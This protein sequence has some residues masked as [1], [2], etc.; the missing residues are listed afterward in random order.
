MA[1][2][3]LVPVRIVESLRLR[4]G[5]RRRQ[6][7]VSL[8]LREPP[9]DAVGAAAARLELDQLTALAEELPFWVQ[10]TWIR[11]SV[12]LELEREIKARRHFLEDHLLDAPPPG[13]L[14]PIERNLAI[15]RFLAQKVE[16]LYAAGR[17]V[18]HGAYLAA[19]S[20]FKQEIEEFEIRMGLR[21][22]PS[23]APAKPVPA[24]ATAAEA[25][26]QAVAPKV[27]KPRE[28]L[29]W[30]KVWETLLSERTLRVLLFLGVALLFAAAV[31]LVVL[32]WELFPPWLQVFFMILNTGI[33]YGLG[34]Y[35]REKMGLRGSGIALSAVASLLIPLD[36]YALYLFGGF[37]REFWPEIWLVASVVS[38]G[39]YLLASYFIQADFFGYLVGI[40]AGSVLGAALQVGRVPLVWWQAALLGLALG[41]ALLS[42]WLLRR[43]SRWRVM[44]LPL[45]HAALSAAGVIL[46][47]GGGWALLG[48]S[49][50]EEFRIALMLDWWMVGL[51]FVM[52]AWRFRLQVLSLAA[53]ISF[54]LATWL[55]E[56]VLLNSWKVDTAWYA[57]G[58]VLLVPAYLLIGRRLLEFK[59]DKIFPAYGRTALVVAVL[60]SVGS[61]AWSFTEVAAAAVVHPWLAASI[62]L[63]AWMWRRPSLSYLASL[64]L[65]T[66]ANAWVG[67]RG[68]TVGQLGLAWALLAIGHVALAAF[69]LRRRGVEGYDGPVYL[70]GWL[71]AL[72]AVLPPLVTLDRPILNYA[73][74][75]LAG[76]SGWLAVLLHHRE[77]P[78]LRRMLEHRRW[79]PTLFH[80]AAA[81]PLLPWLWLVWTGYRPAGGPLGL[82]YLGLAWLL[83]GLGLW[84][85]RIQW[86]YGRPWLTVAHAANLIAVGTR[87]WLY[88]QGWTA[89]ILLLT[90]VFFFASARLLHN[91]FWL[92]AGAL[93]FPFGWTLGLNWLGL[94]DMPLLVCLA[95]VVV[96][97]VAVGGLLE[98]YRGVRRFFLRPLYTMAQFCGVF[99][100]GAILIVFSGDRADAALLWGAAG[101]MLL[102][103]GFGLYAWILEQER[104]GH[105][106]AWLGVFAGGFVAVAYSQGRGSSAAKAAMLAVL[107]IL[108]ERGLYQVSVS[109]R[110]RLGWR[111][112]FRKAWRLYRRP[113]LVAGW[114][115]SV[116][117]IVL[118]LVRNLL[119]LGGGWAR[120]NWAIAGLWI[121]T[122]LYALSAWLYRKHGFAGFFVWL[123]GGVAW[124]PWTLLSHLGWYVRGTPARSAYAVSWAVLGLIELL[125]AIGL[126]TWLP[127]G[128]RSGRWTHPLQVIAHLL[129][130]FSLFWGITNVETSVWTFGFG[131]AF[132]L[133][134]MWQDR[135]AK[136]HLSRRPLPDPRWRGCFLYP[137]AALVPVWALFLLAHFAPKAPQTTYGWMLLGFVLPVLFLGRWLER[138]EPSYGLP[139]YLVAYGT[140]VA[141]TVLLVHQRPALILALVF[142]AVVAG[143]SAWTFQEPRWLYPAVALL[144]AALVLTLI[145]WGVPADRRGWGLIGL[146][147]VYLFVTWLLR[148][149]W[150]ALHRYATPILAAALVLIALGLPPSSQDR[151]GAGVGYG[152]AAGLYALA[153]VWLRQPLLFTVAVGLAMVPYGAVV[154]KLG[155]A[156]IDY[157]LAMW[158]G[159]VAALLAAHGLDWKWGALAEGDEGRHSPLW[160]PEDLFPPFAGTGGSIVQ[161]LA[162]WFRALRARLTRWWALPLYIVAYAGAAVSILLS[163]PDRGRSALVLLLATVVYGLAVLRFRKRLW[164]LLALVSG[165]LA[166][167]LGIYWL[168]WADRSAKVAL[169]FA[170]VAWLTALAGLLVQWR[171]SEGA[172]MGRRRGSIWRGWSRPLYA[173]LL[174]DLVVC[175]LATLTFSAESGWV[176]LSS[177]LLTALLAAV[178]AFPVMA[179]LALLLGLAAMIQRLAWMGIDRL[180]WPTALAL[181]ALAYGLVGYL[182]SWRRKKSALPLQERSLWER[183]LCVG[184]WVLSTYSLLMAIGLGV[185]VVTFTMRAILGRPVIA[186]SDLPKVQMVVSVLSVVG[187]FYLAAAVVDRRRWPGY[188]AVGMLLGAWSL[189]WRL[190]WGMREVQWYAIPAGLYLLAVGY[191]EW[192]HGSRSLARWIDRAALVLLLGSSFWESLTR[193]PGWVY[194]FLMG[195][196]GGLILW[197]GSARR[198]RR[199]LYAGVL[200]ILIDI[201][202]QLVEPF[203]RADPIVFFVAGILVILIGILIERNLERVRAFS[204][205]RLEQLEDWE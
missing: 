163:L 145:E 16:E 193:E 73:L 94:R 92:V 190:V 5:R 147:G 181:L 38:L 134:A 174:V 173:V 10:W 42:E 98:R 177:A 159:I 120:E 101:Q 176:S 36:F 115:V 116:G 48:S 29:T 161:A 33:F 187:L 57:L 78:G 2:W 178:W 45:W 146:G 144:P 126:A 151:L 157:G 133:L 41:M 66:A 87:L 143:I 28:P 63:A 102:G 51:L 1:G 171:L 24:P 180:V 110:V 118:A 201:V 6:I 150:V 79:Q 167:V 183:P 137:A 43:E 196:E 76:I 55:T 185:D 194:A 184:G 204:R 71:I 105:V 169:I 67:S 19:S 56:W 61:A 50:S 88:H 200:G 91:R 131:I 83:L 165:Q 199:F 99:T 107:Y 162:A 74:G 13:V 140:A 81:L 155:V 15:A 136:L 121:V 168:G 93:S 175:Q 72:L 69:V 112:L 127:E 152:V 186:A 142:D 21:P 14:D 172:P 80:W 188:A 32:N 135:K 170:P 89:L 35:V 8:G 182:F 202:A 198:L 25:E 103:I 154:S 119:I 106:A 77:A 18:G 86:R 90:A 179:Y 141:G 37:P 148:Q 53:A 197:W 17:M 39:A 34:W 123:A 158:P 47:L 58:L 30:E 26:P 40:A 108:L 11:P 4:Y 52:A 20:E 60:L 27:R 12:R 54:P 75:N 195:V 85:R 129:I 124:A 128:A 65:L 62:A 122:G 164:L 191:L 64:L 44:A 3:D 125:L 9:P 97:Y 205:E 160:R 114:S 117:A 46:P 31:S 96:A 23:P 189:E 153:A 138:D 156:Q 70:S 22:K 149:P 68:A 95:L 132:Y 7:E 130:P 100:F 49:I 203:L 192:T 139:L 166:V 113:I 82:A 104:W 59:E 111:P 109:N 84:L